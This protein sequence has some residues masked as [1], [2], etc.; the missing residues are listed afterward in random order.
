MLVN[1]EFWKARWH[2][3]RIGFHEGRP[4]RF[5][6]RHGARL[7]GARRVLVPLCGKTVDLSFLAGAGHEV[8]G[9]EL[10]ELAGRA[11]FKEAGLSPHEEERGSLLRLSAENVELWIG[12]FF[13]TSRQL[14]GDVDAFYDRAALVALPADLR[15][16]Y[17]AHL[18]SLLRAG[19][20]GLLVTY[21]YDQS[22]MEGPPFSVPR[23][24]VHALWAG[25]RIEELE[26]E[27]AEAPRLRELGLEGHER[28]YAITLGASDEDR[29][30]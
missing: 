15:R 20:R 26:R 23:E 28:C 18:R 5:L 7:S 9:V 10:S 8:V 12:D 11:Y 3:G 22:A 13:D 17:V 14:L 27:P 29:S 2:E 25:A 19:G 21:E 6:Q 16:R 4:N 30:P 24:E 1:P